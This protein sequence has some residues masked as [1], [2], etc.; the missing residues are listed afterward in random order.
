MI[1]GSAR[2]VAALPAAQGCSSMMEPGRTLSTTYCVIAAASAWMARESGSRSHITV[3]RPPDAISN[4]YEKSFLA[5][6]GRTVT[7]PV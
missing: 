1:I 4:G 6:G 2:R 7:G 5:Y 3:V